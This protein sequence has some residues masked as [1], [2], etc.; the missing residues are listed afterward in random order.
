MPTTGSAS[1][2]ELVMFADWA[3]GL[4]LSIGA[5]SRPCTPETCIMGPKRRPLQEGLWQ[6]ERHGLFGD[7]PRVW[8]SRLNPLANTERPSTKPM[9][10]GLFLAPTWNFQILRK[11]GLPKRAD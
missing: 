4:L 2:R 3:H 10:P 9:S 1:L 6:H 7:T 11:G 5:V 8:Q